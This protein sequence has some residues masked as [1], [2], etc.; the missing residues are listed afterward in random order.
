MQISKCSMIIRFE[1][2][3]SEFFC[4]SFRTCIIILNMDFTINELFGRNIFLKIKQVKLKK[5]I[6]NIQDG[7]EISAI[8][9]TDDYLCYKEP[10]SPNNFFLILIYNELSLKFRTNGNIERR[11]ALLWTVRATTFRLR[12]HKDPIAFLTAMPRRSD[13]KISLKCYF[14]LRK[15]HR[16]SKI[17]F[18][19]NVTYL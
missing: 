16:T 14:I 6:F 10:K 3:H 11:R 5:I 9:V 7:R 1:L 12:S 13:Q 17:F 8:I 19:N 2:K 18:Q 15:L 4:S